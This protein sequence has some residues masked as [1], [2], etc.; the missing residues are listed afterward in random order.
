M[1]YSAKPP[2][3]LRDYQPGDTVE[4]RGDS[5]GRRFL[6]EYLR[7]DGYYELSLNGQIIITASPCH[8]VYP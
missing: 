5:R 8:E 1:S 7:A 4:I 2:P 6:I 3:R